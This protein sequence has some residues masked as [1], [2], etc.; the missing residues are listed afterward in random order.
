MLK[1]L[2]YVLGIY[3][4]SLAVTLVVWLVIVALR[5]ISSDHRDQKRNPAQL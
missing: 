5:W 1:A 4:V 2:E 3:G